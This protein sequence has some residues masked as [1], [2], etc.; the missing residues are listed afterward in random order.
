MKKNYKD[1]KI[2]LRWTYTWT[3]KEQHS[4]RYQIGK[5][6]AIMVLMDSGLN[7]LALQLSKCL[8]EARIL[9]WMTKGKPH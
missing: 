3:L 7:K 4:R 5:Q 8:E 9:E 2:A 6:L 1:S